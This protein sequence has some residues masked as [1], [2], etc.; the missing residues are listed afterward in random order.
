VVGTKKRGPQDVTAYA[1][2]DT[3]VVCAS[4]EGIYGDPGV[5]VVGGVGCV[6]RT[7]VG[8]TKKFEDGSCCQDY[9][10]LAGVWKT[11][12]SLYVSYWYAPSCD[13]IDVE[14]HSGMSLRR[15]AF[16]LR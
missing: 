10:E 4:S 11:A 14:R 6:V 7:L 3:G 15:G 8:G 13:S 16:R 12:D 9:F 2:V 1:V 5:Y